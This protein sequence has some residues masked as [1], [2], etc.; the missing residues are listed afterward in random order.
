MRISKQT[1]VSVLKTFLERNEITTWQPYV[2]Q[3]AVRTIG[4][5]DVAY[6]TKTL[7]SRLKQNTSKI[8]DEVILS[9]SLFVLHVGRM[10]IGVQHY[11]G[12][13]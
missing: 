3:L 2:Y 6:G 5:R 7:G 1:T 4:T 10:K 12:K 9:H 11:N 13:R 8:L